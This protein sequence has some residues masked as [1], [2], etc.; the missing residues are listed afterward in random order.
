MS[1]GSHK[2]AMRTALEAQ[3]LASKFNERTPAHWP[4]ISVLAAE[5]F[6][7]SPATVKSANPSSYRYVTVEPFL[8][9]RYTKFNGNNGFVGRVASDIERHHDGIAQTFT[10]WSY[11]HSLSTTGSAVMVCDIQGVGYQYTDVTLCSE[12]RRFGKT[13]LGAVA[14]E[15]FFSTHKCNELALCERL[16][17]VSK[18]PIAL[19]PGTARRNTATSAIEI[20]RSKHLSKRKRQRGVETIE[21]QAAVKHGQKEIE[22][23]S[24]RVKHTHNRVVVVT[25]TTHKVGITTFAQKASRNPFVG[26]DEV[27]TCRLCGTSFVFTLGEQNFFKTKSLNKPSRCVQCRAAKRFKINQAPVMHQM[28][29]DNKNSG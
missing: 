20:I 15:G 7:L 5:I 2:L 24:G 12:D 4:L 26:K 21:M 14:F 13:D 29:Q 9:G 6:R 10:H 3:S 16:G 28:V 27:L 11:E 17:L 1:G 8:D 25:D 22:S 19:G 23:L 18:A